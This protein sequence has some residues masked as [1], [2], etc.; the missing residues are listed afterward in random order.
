V[1]TPPASLIRLV[2]SGQPTTALFFLS[3]SGKRA[4]QPGPG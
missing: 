4:R 1:N 3:L 2:C